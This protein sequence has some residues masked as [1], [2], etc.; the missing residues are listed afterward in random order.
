MR[1]V[2]CIISCV[3]EAAKCGNIA[4]VAMNRLEYGVRFLLLFARAETREFSH[5]VDLSFQIQAPSNEY[6]AGEG[7][8]GVILEKLTEIA[9]WNWLET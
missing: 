3:S 7:N 2:R 5:L 9:R 1:V 4:E 6:R 8:L